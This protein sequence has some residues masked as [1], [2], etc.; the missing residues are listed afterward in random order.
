MS[1][2]DTEADLEVEIETFDDTATPTD[3]AVPAE[4]SAGELTSSTLPAGDI[5]SGHER[6]SCHLIAFA[7]GRGG[8]G[9]S[10]IA[11][12]VAIYLAQAGKKVV[13][14]DAD[15]AGGPL[16]QL[17][18]ASRTTRGYSEMLRGRVQDFGEL[19]TDTPIAGVRLVGGE[20]SIFGSLKT[21]Q[22]A[23]TVL[24]AIRMLEADYVV[25]DLGSPE[26]TLTICGWRR[27][28]PWW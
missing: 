11:A 10:L 17:L 9:R 7:A 19:L 26:S 18:G 2:D 14:I 24:G 25:L 27:I 23:K 21:K 6:P 8:T 12:N 20:S 15:P 1:N 28:C 13:A 3:P 16:H 22:G 4:A 5:V